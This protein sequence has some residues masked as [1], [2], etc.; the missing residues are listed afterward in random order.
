MTDDMSWVICVQVQG[1]ER[2]ERFILVSADPQL[3]PEPTHVS[4]PLIEGDIREELEKR[5]MSEE[6]VE[7][8][9]QHA[10]AFKTQTTSNE[11]WATI[12]GQRSS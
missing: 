9:L 8:H 6:Q 12:F 2:S 11:W 4:L 5:G 10:R 1:D 7:S 3:P